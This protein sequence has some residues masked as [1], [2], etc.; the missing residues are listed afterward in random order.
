MFSQRTSV[1]YLL[2]TIAMNQ[3]SDE[4][5]GDCDDAIKNQHYCKL[6]GFIVVINNP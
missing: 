3:C 2:I 6:I 4:S 1:R 5:K